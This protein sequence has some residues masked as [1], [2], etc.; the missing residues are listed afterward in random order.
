MNKRRI[1]D[2]WWSKERFLNNGREYLLAV[3]VV[4]QKKPKSSDIV[5]SIIL[6]ELCS[7]VMIA[8]GID[9]QV[10]LIYKFFILIIW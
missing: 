3:V 1:D 5:Y 9:L 7:L 2:E 8:V 4:L 6:V 10:P